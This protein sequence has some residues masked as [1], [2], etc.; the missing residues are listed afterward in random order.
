M[1]N[2]RSDKNCTVFRC[3][4]NGTFLF[5]DYIIIAVIIFVHLQTCA[6]PSENTKYKATFQ[7]KIC[8]CHLI[9]LIFANK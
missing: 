9:T 2:V 8:F 7:S 6:Q 4:E 1:L 3:I 5:L